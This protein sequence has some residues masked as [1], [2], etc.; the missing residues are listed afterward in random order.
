MTLPKVLLIEDDA[1]IT[2]FVRMAL[3]DLEIELLACTNVVD[4]WQ[5]LEAGGIRLVLTDLMLPGESGID[6]MHR[7][8][9]HAGR[10]PAVPVAVFSAGL[11]PPVRDELTALGVWRMLSKPIPV[12]ELEGCVREALTLT[13]APAPSPAGNAVQGAPGAPL[14]PAESEA[15]ATHFGGDERLFR[16]YRELPHAVCSR[17]Q[18]G[19]C[20]P[21]GRR[22]AGLAPPCPQPWHRAADAGTPRAQC[23]GQ[24][25]GRRCKPP[26]HSS[27]PAG[28][29]APAQLSDNP[30][31]P[32]C[33]QRRAR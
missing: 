10:V 6:L 15:V 21:R 2:Q 24:G 22:L 7:L 30:V 18:T 5:V 19:R 29:G 3:E 20:C 25:T 16:A 13:G 12:M 8:R 11:T 17:C 32:A 33:R 1:S 14:T 23:R 9:N 31:E 4:A 28:L 26:R 27:L